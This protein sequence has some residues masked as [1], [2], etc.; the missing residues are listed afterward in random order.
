MIS[1]CLVRVICLA[2]A[3]TSIKEGVIFA[4]LVFTVQVYIKVM[5]RNAAVTFSNHGE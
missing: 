1:I 4:L 2:R 5:A 3:K